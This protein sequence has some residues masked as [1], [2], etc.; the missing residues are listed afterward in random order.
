MHPI[1]KETESGT[2]L[3]VF[4]KITLTG[5]MK[6]HPSRSPADERGLSELLAELFIVI[7][8]IA[9]AVIIIGTV[10]GIIPRL[11]EQPVL[12]SVKAD[13][14]TT[15]AGADVITL[16]HQQGNAVN[17]NGSAQTAGV[18]PV[19]FTLT[20]PTDVLVNVR[21]SPS[22]INDAWRPGGR[23]YIYQVGGYYFVT[24]DP[25]FLD[26]LGPGIDVPSGSWEVNL[27]DARVHLLL[28]K[29]PITIP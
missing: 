16:F 21:S 5:I 19:S 28:H 26:G 17:L 3:S 29:H 8:I 10:T 22:I 7:L 24:D 18:S 12:L 2:G 1:R 23:V 27:I 20:T 14:A 13:A 25:D 15:S 6:H 9:L 11:L 4:I